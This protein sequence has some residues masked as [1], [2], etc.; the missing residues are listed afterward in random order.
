MKHVINIK[1]HKIEKYTIY[2]ELLY[3][4]VL[5]FVCKICEPFLNIKNSSKE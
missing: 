3:Y 4:K 5:K 2:M 1:I